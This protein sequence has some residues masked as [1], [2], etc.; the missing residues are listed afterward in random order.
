MVANP[1]ATKAFA[2]ANNQ[3]G[4]TDP[5]DS[6]MLA[7]FGQAMT[8]RAW[9]PPSPE[10]DVLRRI[11]RRRE[12][13]VDMRRMEKQRRAEALATGDSYTVE[14]VEHHI[15]FLDIQIKATEK[16]ALKHVREHEALSRW[17]DS[18]LSIPGVANITAVGI[19]AELACMPHD[20]D[21][22]QVT[23][24]VGLD[25]TPHQSGKADW[26][27]R[28]SRRGNK[29]LRTLLYLAAWNTTRCSPEV[30]AWRERLIERGKAPKVADVAVS[31][32][33]LLVA[34]AMRHRPQLWD[35]SR[36]GATK[37]P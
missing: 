4:K 3:R 26:K 14:A 5:L 1:R 21:N 16:Q 27:R 37:V 22:K 10:A 17:V 24:F 8:F 33:L 23:A 30:K 7:L 19:V 2:K 36:F 13:L 15:A 6:R 20:L 12:Q 25:P 34:R 29:R 35:G 32:K 18:M 9:T 11:T 28:I 31:R